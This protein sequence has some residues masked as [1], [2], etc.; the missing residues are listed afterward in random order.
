MMSY[1]DEISHTGHTPPIGGADI[2]YALKREKQKT[3][4]N[5]GIHLVLSPMWK[6]LATATMQFSLPACTLWELFISG[7]L[8]AQ[9]N[10]CT[11]FL[12]V[13]RLKLYQS[14]IWNG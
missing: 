4:P 10:L 9:E 12:Q 5:P 14:K 13:N 3:C 11:I 8:V 7:C 1:F 6:S 2:S